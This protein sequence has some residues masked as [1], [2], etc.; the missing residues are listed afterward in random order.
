M[1]ERLPIIILC[2]TVLL[3]AFLG[4]LS[5]FFL[6]RFSNTVLPKA[7]PGSR[8]YESRYRIASCLTLIGVLMLVLLIW[9]IIAIVLRTLPAPP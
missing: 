7:P 6:A 1:I 2:I 3:A 5:I 4:I 9:F 8:E